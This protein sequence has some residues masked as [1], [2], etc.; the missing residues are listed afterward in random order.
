MNDQ[1]Q[2]DAVN[3]F[4][5]SAQHMGE[6]LNE[7]MEEVNTAYHS[8]Q[9]KGDRLRSLTASAAEQFSGQARDFLS[10]M[11]TLDAGFDE[12]TARL[13]QRAEDATPGSIRRE[14]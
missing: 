12:I 3:S 10:R 1:N 8:L 9:E 2:R 6:R 14:R 11:R 5:E 7:V 13:I 4:L